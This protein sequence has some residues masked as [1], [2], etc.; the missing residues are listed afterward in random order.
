MTD[1]YVEETLIEKF[2]ELE[3]LIIDEEATTDYGRYPEVAFPNRPFIRPEDGYWY[4]L[5]FTP[6]VPVQKELGTGGRSLWVGIMQV[7][8]CVPKNAG[9]EAINDRYDNVAELYKSS[10]FIDGI[11]IYRT[12][13][14]SA[15]DDDDFY[16]MPVSIEWQAYLDR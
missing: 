8:I 14:T 12:Y 10:S 11:R 15:L 4:E 7:N 5:S 13:R 2:K 6:S 1:S 16:V 9:I 3:G